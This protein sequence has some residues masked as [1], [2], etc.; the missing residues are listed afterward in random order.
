M[1]LEEI[2]ESVLRSNADTLI[3][4]AFRQA[5][6]APQLAGCGRTFARVDR[7]KGLAECFANE[8]RVL[9]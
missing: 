9:I 3:A 7:Y 5:V 6:G 8:R 4:W 2:R 1:T